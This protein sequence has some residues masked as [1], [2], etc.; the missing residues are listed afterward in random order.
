MDEWLKLQLLL[1]IHRKTGSAS[2]KRCTSFSQLII[3]L[4][5]LFIFPSPDLF[6]ELLPHQLPLNHRLQSQ[7]VRSWKP[8][9]FVALHSAPFFSP[10]TSAA[11]YVIFSLSDQLS[12]GSLTCFAQCVLSQSQTYCGYGSDFSQ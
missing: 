4:I 3:N 1:R 9:L 12:P 8:Q 11:V 5:P 10:G 2:V 7:H 6:E